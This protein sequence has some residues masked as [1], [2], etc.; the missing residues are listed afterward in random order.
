MYNHY[1]YAYAP[2]EGTM[3]NPSDSIFYRNGHK[4]S[5]KIPMLGREDEALQL[6]AIHPERL[7]E[8]GIIEGGQFVEIPLDKGFVNAHE[9]K[10]AVRH[11]DTISSFGIPA[12]TTYERIPPEA[13]KNGSKKGRGLEAL[14]DIPIILHNGT[15]D[16]SSYKKF[17]C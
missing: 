2:K 4:P 14:A 3:L 16:V 1:L 11:G 15:L 12:I 10:M 8:E 5:D 9:T 17:E 13:R 6:I 7:K